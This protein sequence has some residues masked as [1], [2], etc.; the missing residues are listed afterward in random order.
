MLAIKDVAKHKNKKHDLN[1]HAQRGKHNISHQWEEEL[2][3][4]Y[5]ID[6]LKEN[7]HY[8]AVG[9]NVAFDSSAHLVFESSLR[10]IIVLLP[11]N[12]LANSSVPCI[13]SK[14]GF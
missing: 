13:Q 14:R 8:A 4:G 9:T 12:C 10:P 11:A 6:E 1:P 5:V 7:G 3:Q 2:P